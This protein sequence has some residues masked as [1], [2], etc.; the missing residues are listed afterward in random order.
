MLISATNS[1]SNP[2]SSSEDKIDFLMNKITQLEE[3]FKEERKIRFSAE[4]EIKN[5]KTITI[6]NL[7][8]QLEEKESM[9]KTL[10]I[11]KI[12]ITKEFLDFKK[13]VKI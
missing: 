7:Q 3:A 8:K 6:N 2:K 4:E 9:V 10:F 11:E 1:F 5:I 13:N 12:Q